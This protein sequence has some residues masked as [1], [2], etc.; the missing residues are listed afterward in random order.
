MTRALAFAVLL[1]LGPTWTGCGDATGPADPHLEVELERVF[2]R[3]PESIPYSVTNHGWTEAR[4]PRCGGQILAGLDRWEGEGWVGQRALICHPPR[5]FRPL[6][7]PP[8]ATI[9]AEHPA[10]RLEPGTYRLRVP[11]RSETD[12]RPARTIRSAPFD[13][14]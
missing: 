12:D 8:G 10:P 9:H 4:V 3:G 6:E 5:G 13:V 14:R 2:F 7:L 11:A 1:G